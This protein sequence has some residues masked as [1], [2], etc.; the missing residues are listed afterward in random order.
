MFGVWDNTINAENEDNEIIRLTTGADGVSQTYMKDD[1]K[2]ETTST[3]LYCKELKAPDG[4]VTTDKI[5]PF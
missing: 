3:T 2:K 5:Y 1:I 4:Y